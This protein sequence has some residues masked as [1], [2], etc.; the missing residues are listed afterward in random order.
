MWIVELIVFLAAIAGVASLNLAFFLWMPLIFAVLLVATLWSALSLWFLGFCW[1]IFAVAAL[2]FGIPQL[3]KRFISKPIFKII[4]KNFPKMSR[5]EKEAI[6]AGDVWWERELFSGKPHWKTL[7]KYS[8]PKLTDEEQSFLDNQV[9]SLCKK[10][11]RWEITQRKDLPEEVWSDLK[12]N[13]FFGMC[14]PREYGGL[15]F[16]AYAHSQVIMT[17]GMYSGDA[18][19]TAMVPNSL[20]PAELLMKYGTEEQKQHYLPRLADGRDIPCFGLTSLDA[21]SDA[22]GMNDFGI[23]CYGEYNGEKTLGMKLTWNKRYI[24]LAPIATLLGLAFKLYDPDHLLGD[25]DDIGI[26]LALLPTNHPGVKIGERHFPMNMAFMNGPTQGEEV[27]VPMDWVIGGKEKAGQGW[28]MLMECLSAGRGISLPSLS[29]AMGKYAYRMTGAYAQVRTQFRLAICQFDGV[30]YELAQMAGQTYLLHAMRLFVLTGI[31][32]GKSPAIASAIAK[33][34]MTEMARDIVNKAMDI[35]GGKAIQTGP[36]NY[37]ADAYMSLPVAITVEGANILTRSLIIFGQGAI[38]CHPYLLQELLAIQST[39]KDRQDHFDTL[40]TKHAGHFVSRTM[41]MLLLGFSRGW[42][43]FPRVKRPVKKY[44]R[45]LNRLSAAL[46]CASDLSFM[47]LGGKLKRLENLSARLGDVLSYLFLASSVL[48]YYHDTQY[49]KADRDSVDWCIR[50]CL[51]KAESALID[52]WENFPVR[53][54]GFAFK[55]LAFPYGR[56]Y[57]KPSDRLNDKIVEPMIAQSEFRDRLT[58]DGVRYAKPNGV[59]ERWSTHS[60]SA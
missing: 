49:D 31:M 25:N 48:K 22:S 30:K 2:M 20:G 3:R 9:A 41:K 59:V 36:K 34:H 7:F 47:V 11:D 17:L 45:Q 1:L 40:L 37:L 29:T 54:I 14:I 19:I 46:A 58:H 56:S 44:I 23:V 32:E 12:N 33:Y 13:K 5:T 60:S 6:E 16:S 52:F 10:L 55:W 28:R 21:G 39:H 42:L 51:H 38:R 8:I 18:A 26:T 35:H 53:S 57:R 43:S 27:F 4:Q 24:T 50:Y 15:G